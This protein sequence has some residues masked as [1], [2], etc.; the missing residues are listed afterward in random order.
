MRK[1]NIPVAACIGSVVAAFGASTSAG[2]AATRSATS[3]A[4]AQQQPQRPN[5][6]CVVCE[7]ICPNLGC[8]GDRVAKTPN[9]DAFSR[10]AIRYNMYTTIGVSAPSRFS[11]ITGLYPSSYGANQM[12]VSTKAPGLEAKGIEP[13]QV[14]LP[15]GMVCYTELM[16]RAGYYCTNN[17]K[18]DYQFAP[19]LTAWDEC[20]KQAHW[21]NR[22][23]GMPFLAI[24]NL[25]VT[26]E[27]QIWQR[28]NLPLQIDPEDVVLP[29]YYPD[30]PVVRHDVAVNYSNIFEMDRQAQKLFDQ[31]RDAGLLD[32]TII[33]WYSDNGGPLPRRKR[34]VYESGALVPFMIRLPDGYRKGEYEKRL[35]MFADI[36]ATILSLAGIEPPKYM[37]GRAF[38]GRHADPAP[39]KY[40][41][42]AHD[43]MDEQV[44]KIGCV[45]DARY[46]YIR[47][48]MP[49]QPGYTPNRYRLQMPMMVRMAE[50]YRQGLLNEVQSRWFTAPRPEEEFYDVEADPHEINNLIGDPKYRKH[51]ARLKA[52]YER[53]VATDNKDWMRPEIEIRNRMWPAG[54]QPVVATPTLRHT[55]RG[56]EA[57]CE[58]PGAS[59][60]YQ[61]NGKAWG[62]EGQ[63]MLYS[64]P[65]TLSEGDQLAV[66]GVRIGYRNSKPSKP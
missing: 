62:R 24:F 3:S 39:R 14:T 56:I 16:R 55:D 1:A 47:N 49:E 31:V 33:I 45:R 60:A 29:P 52:E 43:R 40:V 9:L 17:A 12:R 57:T 18:T 51:I 35:V 46:R 6:L 8:F 50:M 22:P 15:E 65:I 42:G 48:Y 21:R 26:H 11:L 32:N 19:P 53:W 61:I 4:P 25:D 13:Y 38:L 54:T 58:T 37:Q 23:E 41:Y 34:E 20:S 27:S 66:V 30:D 63:W 64:G 10:E 44:D 5:I 2:A 7:D 36:P 28:G 59:L